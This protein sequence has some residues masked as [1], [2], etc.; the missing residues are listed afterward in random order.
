V[1][2]LKDRAPVAKEHVLVIP[3]NHTEDITKTPVDV[4]AHVAHAAAVYA[5]E[6]MPNGS[7]IIINTGT[8]GGQT[9]RHFHAH[10]IGGEKLKDL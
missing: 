5:R 7:R 4:I 8:D 2:V 6:P 9:V 1:I 3:K 10:V